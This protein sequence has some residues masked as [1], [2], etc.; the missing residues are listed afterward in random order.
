MAVLFCGSA[1]GNMSGGGKLF[2]FLIMRYI[3]QSQITMVCFDFV[4][5]IPTGRVRLIATEGD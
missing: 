2:L 1:L 5:Q 3:Y 4:L